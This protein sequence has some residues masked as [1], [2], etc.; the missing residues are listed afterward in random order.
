MVCEYIVSNRPEVL[1][2][3]RKMYGPN[4]DEF[5][6]IICQEIS[7]PRRWISL[8]SA[9]FIALALHA[10]VSIVSHSPGASICSDDFLTEVD[11]SAPMIW[12]LF[13]RFGNAATHAPP[14]HFGLLHPLGTPSFRSIV[15]NVSQRTFPSTAIDL[16]LESEGDFSETDVTT[17]TEQEVLDSGTGSDEKSL[18]E[19]PSNH[20]PVREVQSASDWKKNLQSYRE[21]TILQW[22]CTNLIHNSRFPMLKQYLQDFSIGIVALQEVRLEKVTIHGYHVESSKSTLAL[23]AIKNDLVYSRRQDIE[24]ALGVDSV[25]IELHSDRHP[26]ILANIYVHPTAS[27]HSIRKMAR[28]LETTDNIFAFGDFNAGGLSDPGAPSKTQI[29]RWITGTALQLISPDEDTFYRGS[30]SSRL[31]LGLTTAPFSSYA[32]SWVDPTLTAEHVS[33]RY[34]L[35]LPVDSS[36]DSAPIDVCKRTNWRRF[37]LLASKITKQDMKGMTIQDVVRRIKDLI[38]QSHEQKRKKKPKPWWND[39]C[40]AALRLRTKAW[41]RFRKLNLMSKEEFDTIKKYFKQTILRAKELWLAEMVL[42]NAKYPWKAIDASCGNKKM[43]KNQRSEYLATWKA[44][45]LANEL[46]QAFEAIQLEQDMDEHRE[47]FADHL[48]TDHPLEEW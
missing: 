17:S 39:S 44:T 19:A 3:L 36:S 31:D 41:K 37:L 21:V 30:Q 16:T 1:T 38:D 40:R 26:V 5:M 45:A 7:T 10:R 43:R 29:D 12:I 15:E 42:E 32:R 35:T 24:D 27:T 23:T 2:I 48:F 47:P 9:V 4:A 18:L 20:T 8:S 22:N 28:K 25:C 6:R 46:C 34:N 33:L 11:C 14:N 13:H